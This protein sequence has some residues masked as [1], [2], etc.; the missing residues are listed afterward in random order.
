VLAVGG[1]AVVAVAT[2]EPWYAISITPAGVAVAQERLTS[3]SQQ[4]GNSAFHSL[5]NEVGSRIGVIA[6]QP[7]ATLSAHQS[8]KDVSTFLLLLAGAALLVA[9]L[10]LAGMIDGGGGLI[11]GL[12]TVA[13]LC[14]LVRM[15]DPPNLAPGYISLS[16]AWGSL[17]ALSGAVAVAV[18]GMGVGSPDGHL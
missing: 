3:L 10:R 1:G 13:V 11:A 5:A 6:G 17:L 7:I 12:G 8:M 2:F 18:G 9:L 15:F 4:F 14:V 16:L